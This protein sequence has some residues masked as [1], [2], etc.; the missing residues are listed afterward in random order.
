LDLIY[1][2]DK[3]WYFLEANE[4]GQFLWIEN[5]NPEIV[6]FKP[7]CD[8]LVGRSDWS[9]PFSLHQMDSTLKIGALANRELQEK[10]VREKRHLANNEGIYE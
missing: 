9:P 8:F 1:S 7:F 6:L 4:G 10:M 5:Y 2:T 3:E